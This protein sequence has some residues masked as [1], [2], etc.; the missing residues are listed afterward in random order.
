MFHLLCHDSSLTSR[1]RFTETE[2]FLKDDLQFISLLRIPAA[3]V[4]LLGAILKTRE[5]MQDK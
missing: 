3:A 2:Y 5:E 1:H 4:Y